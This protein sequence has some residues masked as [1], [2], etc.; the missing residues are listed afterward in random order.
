MNIT[1][2]LETNR[3]SAT[4][5]VSAPKLGQQS[6]LARFRFWL[7]KVG[8]SYGYGCNHQSFGHL[9]K[10]HSVTDAQPSKSSQTDTSGTAM[11]TTISTSFWEAHDNLE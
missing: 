11:P 5:T 7:T 10:L 4:T 3:I 8:P 1:I 6:V 2:V 9:P